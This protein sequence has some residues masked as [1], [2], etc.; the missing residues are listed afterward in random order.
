MRVLRSRGLRSKNDAPRCG[1]LFPQHSCRPRFSGGQQSPERCFPV[2]ATGNTPAQRGCFRLELN[3]ATCKHRWS[4]RGGN[5]HSL[6]ES[7][8]EPLCGPD[9]TSSVYLKD[10]PLCLH[11]NGTRENQTTIVP[12]ISNI[13]IMLKKRAFMNDG[14]GLLSFPLATFSCEA[15][16]RIFYLSVN[17]FE[18]LFVLTF[19]E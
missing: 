6:S 16:L 8:T 13:S 11:I 18:H 2:R 19:I 5:A 17:T 15:F 10:Q 3:M 7:T 1:K 4:R 9:H 14:H 12:E